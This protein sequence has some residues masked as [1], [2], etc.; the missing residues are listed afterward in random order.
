MHRLLI[1]LP[2]FPHLAKVK[3]G[4]PDVPDNLLRHLADLVDPDIGEEVAE[5]L[6]L[7][8]IGGAC[9]APVVCESA[10]W[11]RLSDSFFRGW[12][13]TTTPPPWLRSH[14]ELAETRS[15]LTTCSSDR[16]N[17]M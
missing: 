6:R 9:V 3:D 14:E 12:T 15:Q 8:G 13:S 17:A 7:A 16:P 4:D 1:T 11:K 10:R 2:S 5:S